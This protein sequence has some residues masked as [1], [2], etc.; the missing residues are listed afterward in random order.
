M[1][2]PEELINYVFKNKKLLNQALTHSS[3]TTDIHKNYERLEFLGDRILG[4]GVAKMLYERFPDE[5]EGSLSQRHMALV[6]KEAVSEVVKNLGL[7]EYII[8]ANEDAK[9]SINVLCDVGE[10]VIAAICIDSNIDNAI[11]FV[12]KNW[13][14]L[15]EKYKT[16]PKDAKTKLQEVSWK[17]KLG[18][19]TYE[20]VAKSGS[21][22]LPIFTVE[23]SLGKEHKALG[24]GT[25]KKLAE[26][27][28][29]RAMLLMLGKI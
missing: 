1:Q 8:I 22:H 24:N 15:L 21:E 28:A 19:P 4:V 13:E 25:N 6:C 27:E 29:A 11:E 2:N 23:V 12:H 10:A 7:D 14:C 5:P 9:D 20:I 17:M 16:P 26:Q 3:S 18:N